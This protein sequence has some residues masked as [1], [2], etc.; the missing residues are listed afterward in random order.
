VRALATQVSVGLR[1]ALKRGAARWPEASIAAASAAGRATQAL[2]RGLDVD[3]IRHVF[4]DLSP[5]EADAAR[6]AAWS[7]SL[8]SK[9]LDAALA[10]PDARRPYPRLR[11]GPDPGAIARPAVLATCHFGPLRA[12][13]LL[14]E[15]MPA[16]V[17][18]L[19]AGDEVKAPR[20]PGWTIVHVGPEEWN[21]AAA[22]RRSLS[23]LQGGGFVLVAVDGYGAQ[24]LEVPLL[25]RRVRLARGAFALARISGAPVVPVT[26]RWRGSAVEIVAGDPLPP[27]DEQTLATA[28]AGWMEA[29]ARE[30]PGELSTSFV[31]LL[32]SGD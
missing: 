7:A 24:P 25:D 23:V 19:E 21:R 31:N 30:A 1:T 16:E 14:F 2:G 11:S 32:G 29:R 28:F 9:V 3:S 10:V 17:L 13:G 18:A 15:R 8:R 26:P 22:F 20:R 6:R 4:P 5:D 27:G 12:L